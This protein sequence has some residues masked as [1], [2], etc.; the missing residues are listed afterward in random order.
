MAS[1]LIPCSPAVYDAEAAL[2]EYGTVVW[3]Q[4][5]RMKPGDFAYLYM[6]APLKAIR[7]KCVIGETELPFDCG[8][9]DGYVIDGE[10]CARTYRRYMELRLVERWDTPLLGYGF[11]LRNGLGGPVR[12]QRRMPE[13]LEAYVKAVCSGA[14]ARQ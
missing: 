5:C 4:Q 9:D 14:E 10:F 3:H 8:N 1:W 12:S 7:C 2:R 6:T 13:A 11:L